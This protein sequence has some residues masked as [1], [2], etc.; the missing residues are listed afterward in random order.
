MT[1]SYDSMTDT[2]K[3]INVV[4]N[5]MSQAINILIGRAVKHDQSK[6]Y[7]PEKG[8][9]DEF[10]P[11]LKD[12]TYGSD[13]YKKNLEGMGEGL[14]HH[15]ANNSHHPEYYS[16]GITDMSLLDL[17]EMLC[18]WK[19]AS[20]RHKDSDILKSIELN[21]KRYNYSNELKSFLI[22]TVQEMDLI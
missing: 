16:N 14:K 17:L 13:E 11:K 1:E 4:Y 20:L 8:V 22:N 7:E 9:L 21:Q 12:V 3:H 5:Y 6:L 15:Y 18:D 19:A 10:T 2:H